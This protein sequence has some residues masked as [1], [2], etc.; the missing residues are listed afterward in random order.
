MALAARPDPLGLKVQSAHRDLKDRR[1]TRGPLARRATTVSRTTP[2][3]T[4]NSGNANTNA[5]KSC[6]STVRLRPPCRWVAAVRSRPTDTEGVALVADHLR[7]NG[8]FVK[9]ESF[10]PPGQ[11]W[12][13]IAYVTC[14]RVS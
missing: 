2:S 4:H 6:R 12:K 7:G 8:W 14:A 1:A 11:R 10:A 5:V 9:A 3:H 13:V